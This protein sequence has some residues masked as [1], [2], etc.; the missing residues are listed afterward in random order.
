MPWK[1]P[2]LKGKTMLSF[3]ESL[4]Q[5]NPNLTYKIYKFASIVTNSERAI[6]LYFFFFTDVDSAQSVEYLS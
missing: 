2:F 3:H 6:F 5:T 4:W 1:V